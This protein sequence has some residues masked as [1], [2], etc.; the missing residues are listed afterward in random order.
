LLEIRAYKSLYTELLTVA[1][2]EENE[3]AEEIEQE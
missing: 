1:T 2:E 3:E